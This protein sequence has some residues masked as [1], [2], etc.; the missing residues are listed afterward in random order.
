MGARIG[1]AR[2]KIVLRVKRVINS[3]LKRPH[4]DQKENA[5]PIIIEFP[6]TLCKRTTANLL[7]PDKLS[8]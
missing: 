8:V 7:M 6:D 5:S 1:I 3:S 2:T 4:K